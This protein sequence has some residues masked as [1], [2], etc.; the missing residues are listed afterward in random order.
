MEAVTGISRELKIDK[1][2]GQQETV[3]VD[4]PQGVPPLCIEGS[5]DGSCRLP[6]RFPAL[7]PVQQQSALI[8]WRIIRISWT[9]TCA[10]HDSVPVLIWF[11]IPVQDGDHPETHVHI[12]DGSLRRDW[13]IHKA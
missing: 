3:K 2:G 4:I 12:P 9:C 8:I 1:G 11:E 7:E 13:T 5:R 6:S 10:T